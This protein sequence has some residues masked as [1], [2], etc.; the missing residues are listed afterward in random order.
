MVAVPELEAALRTEDSTVIRFITTVG[1]LHTGVYISRILIKG[2][3]LRWPEGTLQTGFSAEQSGLDYP[4]TA[5]S[6]EDQK[7][8]KKKLRGL[9]LVR[10]MQA[11]GPD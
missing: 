4:G 5:V 9:D 7:R 8:E 10:L 6:P 2:T 1:A 11:E 3:G